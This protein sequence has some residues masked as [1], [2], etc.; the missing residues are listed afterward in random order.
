MEGSSLYLLGRIANPMGFV[1]ITKFGKCFVSHDRSASASFRLLIQMAHASNPPVLEN[2]Y[3]K[4][5]NCAPLIDQLSTAENPIELVRAVAY[6]MIGM[7]G[8]RNY[9]I[10]WSI[11]ATTTFTNQA[12][13]IVMSAL[14]LL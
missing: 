7:I 13:C 14:H 1:L 11:Q 4:R 2:R 3:N 12:G 8:P 5:A 10:S 6:A 9:P